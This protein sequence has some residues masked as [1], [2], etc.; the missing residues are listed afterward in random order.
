MA[1]TSEKMTILSGVIIVVGLVFSGIAVSITNINH[2]NNNSQAQSQKVE[3]ERTV[4]ETK[5]ESIAYETK[6]VEDASIEYNQTVVKT[7]GVYGEKT[8]TY[9]VTY[10]GNDEVS[11]KLEKEEV[12]KQPITKVI[13]RGTKIIWHC[14][15]ATSYD[16]NPYNDNK[17]TNSKGEVR[18]VPD[19]T[20]RALDP[21]YSP[22]Q[23]G[24]RYYNSF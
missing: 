19:S 18:Y 10:L 6:T 14:V 1:I 17:C 3:T 15:D 7:E 20:S 12:T 21:T 23:S 11:R 5:K 24:H 2:S 8:Y 22:G 16:K 4:I 9:S 13:A